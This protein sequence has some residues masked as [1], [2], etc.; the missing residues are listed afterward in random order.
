M[1]TQLYSTSQSL[2][3]KPGQKS[4]DQRVTTVFQI[5]KPNFG[6]CFLSRHPHTPYKTS[7]AKILITVYTRKVK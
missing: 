4:L 7:Q 1:R 3:L 5:K 6:L 2:I